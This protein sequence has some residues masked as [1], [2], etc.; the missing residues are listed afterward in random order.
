[1]QAVAG[2]DIFVRVEMVPALLDRI[3]NNIE[4]LKLA[5]VEFDQ[6]LLQGGDADHIFYLECRKL[7]VGAVGLDKVAVAVAK[8]P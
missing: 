4:R 8:E 6:I 2:R 1:M 7:S 3:P 5:A